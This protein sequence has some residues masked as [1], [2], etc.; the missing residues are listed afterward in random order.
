MT[1]PAA[2]PADAAALL[3]ELL[4]LLQD[5]AAHAQAQTPLPLEAVYDI[6][7]RAPRAV[8]RCVEGLTPVP[9]APPP[10]PSSLSAELADALAAVEAH[11]APPP[12]PHPTLDRLSR[13]TQPVT[14]AER[15]ELASLAVELLR[16]RIERLR[17]ES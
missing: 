6:T 3:L 16:A 14:D 9:D 10:S 5:A 7:M 13:F 2:T 11:F 12:S 8:A 4:E 1:E 17:G 15:E